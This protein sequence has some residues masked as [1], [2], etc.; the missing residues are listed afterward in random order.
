M[1]EESDWD[2]LTSEIHC[3]CFNTSDCG[4]NLYGTLTNDHQA[5]IDLS[6]THRLWF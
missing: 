4:L 5:G 1:H 3:V 6:I 2:L